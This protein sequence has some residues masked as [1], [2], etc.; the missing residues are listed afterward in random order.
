MSTG[1]IFAIIFGILFLFT[2]VGFIV[3]GSALLA[4]NEGAV[5]EHGYFNTSKIP[6]G[7]LDDQSVAIVVDSIIIDIDHDGDSMS[8]STKLNPGSFV[9]F[10]L[11]LP[12]NDGTYFAGIAEVE[13]VHDY[14]ATVPYQRVSSISDSQWD[15]D[16]TIDY[17]ISPST[18]TLFEIEFQSVH[19]QSNQSLINNL[20]SDQDFWLE[21]TTDTELLWKPTYGEYALVI[22]KTDGSPN[23]DTDVSIGVRIPILTP[24]GGI[25]LFVGLVLLV[26]SVLLLYAGCRSNSKPNVSYY[27]PFKTE[28]PVTIR[29]DDS[30]IRKVQ[31]FKTSDIKYCK[32]CGE[33]VDFD[34]Q[35]CSACGHKV[36]NH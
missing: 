13:A 31:E 36:N 8:H 22:M 23:V 14:L 27:V 2:S 1:K 16:F 11:Q 6:L 12:H 29:S 17:R 9:Q 26:S 15:E 5:D 24:I 4:L 25:L 32:Q 21:A 3:S 33:G 18:S 10:R 28:E 34:A 7:G 30:D 20:P 35:F 19:P